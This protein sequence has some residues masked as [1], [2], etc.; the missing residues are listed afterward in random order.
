[1]LPV[2]TG[3]FLFSQAPALLLPMWK[4]GQ[5]QPGR[6]QAGHPDPAQRG[7][8]GPTIP[9]APD[10]GSRWPEFPPHEAPTLPFPNSFHQ[11]EEAKQGHGSDQAVVQEARGP[12]VRAP[13]WESG[14]VALGLALSIAECRWPPLT[15]SR[16]FFLFFVVTWHP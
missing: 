13:V 16:P 5:L 12:G 7:L 1:M 3:R 10:L 4:Q 2:V 6:L 15:Y 9:Q 8:S 14:H 11:E